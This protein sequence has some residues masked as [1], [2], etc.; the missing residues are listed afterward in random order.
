RKTEKTKALL[1]ERN[2]LQEQIDSAQ[3]RI[4]EK[5]ER[6]TLLLAVA[7]KGLLTNRIKGT[8][9][10]LEREL[11]TYRDT[12][13]R[14]LVS[15]DL[16]QKLRKAIED[17]TCAT[18]GQDISDTAK[19][20]LTA[21]LSQVPST[22][23]RVEI[24]SKIQQLE[25]RISGLKQSEAAS[26]ADVLK[27]IQDAIDNLKITKAA[28][29]DRLSDIK[30]QTKDLDETD[31]RR[32]YSGYEK[33]LADIGIL[34]EGIKNQEDA[35]NKISENIA[36][37]EAEMAKFADADL[38]AERARKELCEKIRSLV[39]EAVDAYRDRLRSRVEK[40]ATDLFLKLT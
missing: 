28:A 29:E 40:D 10:T 12:Y 13:Q 11:Q 8:R 30:S 6:K 14:L 22:E 20:H 37:V 36:K 15:S 32:V 16:A 3:A 2:R 23:E 34:Q 31:I 1:D 7:W 38:E 5:E 19:K 4:I 26:S 25:S 39:A 24:E 33:T 18:C 9:E 27:E 21:L 17:G 35:L